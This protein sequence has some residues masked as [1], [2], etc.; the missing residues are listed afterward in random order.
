MYAR[1]YIGI[2]CYNKIQTVKLFLFYENFGF[3]QKQ[4]QAHYIL[5][6][7]RKSLPKKCVLHLDMYSHFLRPFLLLCLV[8][9]AQLVR[10][11]LSVIWNVA[12][13][14]SGN[15]HF[16][17]L[18]KKLLLR[19][20]SWQNSKLLISLFIIVCGIININKELWNLWFGF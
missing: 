16:S 12:V 9:S 19:H 8:F 13:A 11:C 4:G 7:Y 20:P 1:I 14:K 2:Q 18:T 10:S 5:L 17:P 15:L 6:N 3:K